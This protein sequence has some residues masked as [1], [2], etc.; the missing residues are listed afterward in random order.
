[1]TLCWRGAFSGGGASW[2]RVVEALQQTTAVAE[3]ARLN[4]QWLQL[5]ALFRWAW[6]MLGDGGS[7]LFQLKQQ[8]KNGE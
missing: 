3:A 2:L 4:T 5:S 8:F 1:M 6:R 7:K